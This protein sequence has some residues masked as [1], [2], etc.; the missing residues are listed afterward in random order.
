MALTVL[1]VAYPL[2]PVGPNAV[3]GAEQILTYLDA[4]LVEAGHHSIVIA[5]EG[6]KARGTLVP[7]SISDWP[8]DEALAWVHERQLSSIQQVLNEYRV[9]V[10]HLHGLNFAKCLPPQ[11]V[12][13]LV[14]LH[15]PASYYPAESFSIMRPRTFLQC[16]SSSQQ[17]SFPEVANLLT[18]IENGVP[19]NGGKTPIATRKFCLVLGRICPEKGFH[20]AIAAAE[21]ARTPLLLGGPVFNFK[22]YQKY[23]FE[24]IAPRCNG[25]ARFIGPVNMQRKRRLLS[26]AKCV[27]IP[28]VVPETSS[29]VAMEAFASG[30]PVIAFR[31]GA[32]TEIVEDGRTGFLVNNEAEM[33]DAISEVRTLDMHACLSAARDRFSVERMVQRYFEIYKTITAP[34]SEK[35]RDFDPSYPPPNKWQGRCARG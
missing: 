28:S 16:V 32:L 23:F 13:V 31:S 3:G 20:F 25:F 7:I 30:T 24:E 26:A 29:L 8:L 1:G 10:V 4:A 22:T 18:Y 21:R 19:F 6:S 27:L 5:C 34:G 2:S 33:A 14:T 12:P 9:D 17:R 11:D 15:L 35:I